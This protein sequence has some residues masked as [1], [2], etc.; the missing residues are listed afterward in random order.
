MINSNSANVKKRKKR[1]KTIRND[2]KNDFFV[3]ILFGVHTNEAIRGEKN[4]EDGN[5]SG[6]RSERKRRQAC[7]RSN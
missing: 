1:K 5:E 6:R 2:F 4:D 3:V 7:G